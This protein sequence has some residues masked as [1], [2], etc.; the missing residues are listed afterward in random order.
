MGVWWVW[1]ARIR[2]VY[3]VGEVE[4]QDIEKWLK[5]YRTFM[6]MAERYRRKREKL[7]FDFGIGAPKDVCAYRLSD[8]RVQDGVTVYGALK[9]ADAIVKRY[10][11][12]AEQY[13]KLRDGFE[14]KADK[15]METV[16]AVLDYEEM[17]YI[18]LRY[19]KGYPVWQVCRECCF[20]ENTA[21][22][23]KKRA[24]AKLADYGGFDVLK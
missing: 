6:S 19:I 7:D 21:L 9:N 23:I 11:L 13:E 14:D 10:R 8:I 22:R 4:I 12:K 2:E 24:F 15:I 16:T 3:P 5:Q 18:D 17:E 20:S 1:G